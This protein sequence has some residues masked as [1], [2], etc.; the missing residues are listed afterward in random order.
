[1]KSTVIWNVATHDPPLTTMQYSWSATFKQPLLLQEAHRQS[2][3]WRCRTRAWMGTR[4]ECYGRKWVQ[5]RNWERP[6]VGWVWGIC[7]ACRWSSLQPSASTWWHWICWW[8]CLWVPL[9]LTINLWWA[10]YLNWGSCLA[11]L[12][13][14]AYIKGANSRLMQIAICR[15]W[16]ADVGIR[17][18][19][20]MPQGQL[21]KLQ[22]DWPGEL[23]AIMKTSPNMSVHVGHRA[24][25]CLLEGNC[26]DSNNTQVAETAS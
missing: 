10:G 7:P 11:L 13:S 3:S 14:A 25:T 1:M 26:C 16:V 24:H 5:G 21:T 18:T 17:D 23:Q 6:S 20:P 19:F 15:G 2:H 4:A 22:N 9:K 12:M 8:W